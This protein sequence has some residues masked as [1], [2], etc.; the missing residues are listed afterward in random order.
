MTNCRSAAPHFAVVA[1]LVLAAVLYE[2]VFKAFLDI[3]AR[4]QSHDELQ[5]CCAALRRGR[6]SFVLAAVLYEEV[7]KALLDIEARKQS[8]DELQKCCA[9]LRRGRHSF[10]LVAVLYE[11]V[12]KALPDR[13]T[14]AIP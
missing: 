14:H 4:T 5:K 9:A 13:G 12:F 1:T 8:H 2:E 10:V 7:F 3:E 6:H 11:E